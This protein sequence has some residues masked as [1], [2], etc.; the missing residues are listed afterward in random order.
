MP[1]ENEVRF[2]LPEASLT[3]TIRRL[4]SDRALA[5]FQLKPKGEKVHS[6]TYF[7]VDGA[8]RTRGWS[9]RIRTSDGSVRATLKT[10]VASDRSVHGKVNE[11]LE[12]SDNAQLFD[13]VITIIERLAAA[14]IVQGIP[15]DLTT[16]LLINGAYPTLLAL[17]L[18][19]LFTVRTSRHRWMV[20]D[21]LLDLAELA[22][23]ESYYGV[24]TS[25]TEEDIRECRVEVEL[26]DASKNESLTRISRVLIEDYNLSEVYDSK[27]ERGML[28][29]T[30][31]GLREKLELKIRV[32]ELSDYDA[33][34]DRIKSDTPPFLPPYRFSRIPERTISDVYFD[35]AE[36][37]LFQ[38]GHYL[39]LRHEGRHRELVFRRLTRDVRY[40]QVL[41]EEVVAKGDGQSFLRSWRLI[42]RWLGSSIGRPVTG[43]VKGV[44][45]TEDFLGS[46]GLH[47]TLEVDISRTPFIVERIEDTGPG[48]MAPDHVAKL[49]YDQITMRRPDHEGGILVSREFEATGVEAESASPQEK[50]IPS[51]EAF[52]AQFMEA[53]AHVASDQKVTRLLSAKYFEGMRQ[54]NIANTT[55][56][57]LKDGRL[58]YRVSLLREEPPDEA[59]T[60]D[61]VQLVQLEPRR[62]S[63]NRAD[64][65]KKI[66]NSLIEALLDLDKSES[67]SKPPAN[68]ATFLDSRLRASED[69]VVRSTVNITV[70]QGQTAITNTSVTTDMTALASELSRI[71]D[72]A[73]HS[74]TASNEKI[75]AIEA[76][77]DAANQNDEATVVSSLRKVTAYV[78]DLAKQIG[79]PV[80]TTL[81]EAKFGLK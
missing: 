63:A 4:N 56:P 38:A 33:I 55:P 18:K 8:L 45:E 17:G 29:F 73:K 64:D 50:S 19:D 27:F 28:H 57:W 53:C 69:A 10:P 48:L 79:A 46:I 44:G 60:Y 35:S 62:Q 24:G 22:V 42:Q 23:D 71:A 13:T 67:G 51:Y 41:Q 49:K 70:S 54:L 81:I 47:R 59:N 30:T 39:R 52:V 37:D 5:P 77:R 25:N 1:L 43:D 31:R 78:A 40:G 65:A 12:N 80:A 11:E 36:Q 26:L 61:L 34:V 75:A 2:H 74:R 16:Q 9:L 66:I 58:A 72:E 14:D 15:A 20:S 7:D 68:F 6:D 76:A 3:A 21:G 32:H